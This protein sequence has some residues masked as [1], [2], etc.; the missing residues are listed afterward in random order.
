MDEQ[1][2]CYGFVSPVDQTSNI[3]TVHSNVHFI[4]GSNTKLNVSEMMTAVGL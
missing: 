2:S 4:R 1:N 3:Y